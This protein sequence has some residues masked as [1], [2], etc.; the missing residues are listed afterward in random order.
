MKIV[1]RDFTQPLG[2]VNLWLIPTLSY[3]IQKVKG[4]Q[5]NEYEYVWWVTISSLVLI[6][7]LINWKIKK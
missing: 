3:L 6:W 4:V 2:S 1:K 5:Y 7:G